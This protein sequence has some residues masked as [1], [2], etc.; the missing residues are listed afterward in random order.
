LCTIVIRTVLSS[1]N[2]LCLPFFRVCVDGS[3]RA[4]SAKS[5]NNLCCNMFCMTSLL[6]SFE[7]VLQKYCKHANYLFYFGQK[8]FQKTPQVHNHHPII[9]GKVT[10]IQNISRIVKRVGKQSHHLVSSRE[11]RSL[12]GLNDRLSQYYMGYQIATAV[13]LSLWALHLQSF[14]ME[15]LV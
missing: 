15:V 5:K 14:K 6:F 2:E 3:I 7:F 13:I 10:H 8:N 11:L 1:L 9:L 12:Q 4:L